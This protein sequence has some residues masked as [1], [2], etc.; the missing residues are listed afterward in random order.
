MI[1]H[2]ALSDSLDGIMIALH[3]KIQLL[4]QDNFLHIN[5]IGFLFLIGINR[6]SML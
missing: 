2:N 1:M 3:S 6:M 5:K 4:S